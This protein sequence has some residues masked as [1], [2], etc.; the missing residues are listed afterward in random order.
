MAS[1]AVFLASLRA[2][3]STRY[4]TGVKVSLSKKRA[5]M[6]QSNPSNKPVDPQ[7]WP[8]LEKFNLVQN[9]LD[10]NRLLINEINQNQETRNP[11]GLKRNVLLIRELNDNVTKVSCIT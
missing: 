7:L 5:T 4:R 9:I 8:G 11:D 10:H 3:I 6:E 2:S 1:L